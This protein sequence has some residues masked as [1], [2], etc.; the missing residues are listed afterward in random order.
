M[1]QPCISTVLTYLRVYVGKYRERSN[2]VE[3]DLENPIIAKCC[4]MLSLQLR[5]DSNKLVHKLTREIE[6]KNHIKNLSER[7]HNVDRNLSP[8]IKLNIEK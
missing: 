2:F 4:N 1:K 6:D 5:H 7:M 3:S 8:L